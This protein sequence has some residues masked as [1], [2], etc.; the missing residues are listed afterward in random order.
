MLI[1]TLSMSDPHVRH[2][3]HLVVTALHHL[4][5]LVLD[6][7]DLLAVEGE[8]EDGPLLH[9]LAHGEVE[10]VDVEDAAVDGEAEGAHLADGGGQH[11]EGSLVTPAVVVSEETE[12]REGIEEDI[13]RVDIVDIKYWSV[14][15]SAG[16][17]VLQD[18]QVAPGDGL[19][20]VGDDV[21]LAVLQELLPLEGGVDLDDLGERGGQLGPRED[22]A[23][24]VLDFVGDQ[25]GAARQGVVTLLELHPGRKGQLDQ[26]VKT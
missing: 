23:E 12:N 10:G 20:D 16:S 7:H 19:E 24:D 18:L 26:C 2:P 1:G 25:A 22:G 15:Q 6:A 9:H 5:L 4:A 14:Q 8:D 3:H 17:P 13:S 21:H 11:V